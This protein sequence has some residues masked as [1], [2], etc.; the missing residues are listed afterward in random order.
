[1]VWL[2]SN[3]YVR[4]SILISYLASADLIAPRGSSAITEDEERLAISNLQNGFDVYNLRDLSVV[5]SIQQP[6]SINVVIHVT[7]ARSDSLLITGSDSGCICV[8]DLRIGCLVAS[9][10]H[11]P[12]GTNSVSPRVA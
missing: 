4:N 3:T 12:A 2:C 5:K 8:Y 10:S 6:I 11:L 7:F 1:M 9:L